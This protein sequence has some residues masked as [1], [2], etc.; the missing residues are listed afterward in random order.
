MNTQKINNCIEQIKILDKLQQE[1][2]ENRPNYTPSEI[3]ELFVIQYKDKI[4]IWLKDMK[5][6]TVEE[7]KKLF[8]IIMGT[9]E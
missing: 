2:K 3:D 6:L 9:N 1:L 8:S 4:S 7:T 5:S